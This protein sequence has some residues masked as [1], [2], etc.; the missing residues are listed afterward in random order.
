MDLRF[1]V[2]VFKLFDL[3]SNLSNEQVLGLV[4]PPCFTVYF[5]LWTFDED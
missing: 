2:S 1:R 5:R 3:F 4:N